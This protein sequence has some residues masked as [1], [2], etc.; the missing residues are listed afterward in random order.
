MAILANGHP[1]R[2]VLSTGWMPRNYCRDPGR[3]IV[4]CPGVGLDVNASFSASSAS[5][6]AIIIGAGQAGLAAA[7]H[8][9]RRG[10]QFTVLDANPGPGGA[11][12]HRWDALTLGA[13]HHIHPLPGFALEHQDASRPASA[14]VSEY[15]AEYERRFDLPVR[16]G[17]EIRSVQRD[18]TGFVLADA[19]GR[20]WQAD[21]LINATGT[22]TSPFIPYYP[23]LQD[24]A[25]PQVHTN[26]YR[27][28][29]QFAGQRVLVVGGGASATQFLIALDAAGV[30]TLWSTRRAP[31]WRDAS[32]N[33]EW[34][35]EVEQRVNQRILAGGPA[36]SVVS[37]TG[38]MLTAAMQAGIDSGL[39][40]SRGK[41]ERFGQHQVHFA[42][43]STEQVDAVLWATGF[44]HAHQHLAP[45]HLHNAAGGLN[46]ASDTVSSLDA[47]GLFF[48]G[49]GASASTLGATRAG[50]KAATAAARYLAQ[51]PAGQSQ[52]STK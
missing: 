22:W 26:G 20:R 32:N 7:W 45:L 43:G 28:V 48:V 47:P 30:D 51:L 13:A 49:Y 25:G 12:Q 4:L 3:N 27:G 38:L 11:W 39:L 33:P 16:H 14:V 42:D 5:F 29:E 9:S 1:V 8:L 15:Y 46:L 50:R 19:S 23:G 34:G 41:I 52:T 36:G 17:V 31:D 2:P 18:G 10:V 21:A 40:A 6:P 35:L 24:F 44:R 37:N